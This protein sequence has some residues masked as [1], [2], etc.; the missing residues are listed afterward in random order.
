MH[1]SMLLLLLALDPAAF[2]PGGRFRLEQSRDG[3]GLRSHGVMETIAPGRTKFYSLP[4]ST[5]ADYQQLRPEDLHISPFDPKQ[6]ER[7]E[8]IGPHQLEGE[9]LWFGNAYY[10]G[11]G[12]KGVGA[13]GYFD[14]TTRTYTL[15]RPPEVARYEISAVLV[16]PERVW[17]A[18]D[19][20]GEDI[21]TSPGG[22][23]EWNR[24]THEIHK[25]NL[26][27][28]IESIRREGGSLRLKNRYGGYA[29]LRGGEVHR[30]LASGKTTKTFPPQPSHY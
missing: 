12:D 4:Q 3:F 8:V 15:F 16:E 9:R 20:F 30:F 13:F 10:D 7:Q 27:F 29:V 5:P 17:L 23:V 25:Y 21:S 18:L 6:Y 1:L 11:E 28:V 2:G 26:E 19:R 22:L 24:A 14:T